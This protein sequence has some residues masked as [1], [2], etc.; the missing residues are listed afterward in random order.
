MN[1][2]KIHKFDAPQCVGQELIKIIA[3]NKLVRWRSFK[4]ATREYEI[5]LPEGIAT[6]HESE[7]T[8]EFSI[9]EEL[10][11][12]RNEKAETGVGNE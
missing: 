8:K 5:E 4:P 7:V 11:F 1:G 9:Q 10:D 2:G 12:L 3:T 6:I